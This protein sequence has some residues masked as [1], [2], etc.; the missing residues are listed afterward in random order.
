MTQKNIYIKY[1]SN[2]KLL[3]DQELD[4]QIAALIFLAGTQSLGSDLADEAVETSTAIENEESDEINPATVEVNLSF[5][6]VNHYLI[7]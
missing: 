5:L 7:E 1:R 2:D 6:S 3:M 4:I